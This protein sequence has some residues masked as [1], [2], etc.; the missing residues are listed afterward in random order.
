MSNF[1]QS[2]NSCSKAK[3]KVQKGKTK[4]K[5]KCY[6]CGKEGHI[7]KYCYDFIRKQKQKGNGSVATSSNAACLSEMLTVLNCVIKN[8]WILDSR[9]SFHMSP[10][11]DWFSNFNSNES[12]TVFMGNNDSWKILDFGYII[13]RMH[14]GKNRLLTNV[15]YV[16][17][18]KRNLISLGTLDELGFC[19]KAQKGHLH[20]YKHDNLIL[21]GT[22][23]NGLYVLDGYYCASARTDSALVSNHDMTELWHLRLA[24]MS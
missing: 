21:S 14:D 24:H 13:L 15:R 22:K 16:P 17:G 6:H 7:K 4:G 18:L 19:Y 20:I 1:D 5:W 11:H 8:E 9:C 3:K 10:N 2:G 12:V 23:V